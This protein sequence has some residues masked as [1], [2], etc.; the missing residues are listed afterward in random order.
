MGGKRWTKEEEKIMAEHY[1]KSPT[2]EEVAEMLGRPVHGVFKKG[3]AMGLKRP[4]LHEVSVSRLK[5]ALD[6]ETPRSSLE[7]AERMGI[8][9]NAACHLLSRGYDE[10]ICH[11][12][13]YQS[14]GSRGKDAL[15]WV[16]GPGE[17]AL[18]DYAIEQAE[19]E[20]KRAAHAKKPFKAFRDP[21]VEAFF[22]RAA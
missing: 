7:I 17:N 10:G 20:A 21:L 6:I 11:I 1:E 5:A 4:D 3:A 12:A 18:S 14:N 15:M 22:G 9:R 16:A 19:R 13:E 8:T 2:V